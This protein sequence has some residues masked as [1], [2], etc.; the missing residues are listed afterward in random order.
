M[1]INAVNSSLQSCPKGLNRIRVSAV[2]VAVTESMID[3][4]VKP[5]AVLGIQNPVCPEFVTDN[6][7]VSRTRF[8][9][10][11]KKLFPSQLLAFLVW[12]CY[13]SEYALCGAVYD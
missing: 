7:C 3:R 8:V 2:S 12:E 13:A 9:Y 6:R 11:R 1:M 4:Q 5:L 10:D